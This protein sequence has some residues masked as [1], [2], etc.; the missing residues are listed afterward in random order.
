MPA[1]ALAGV[2]K[3]GE[4]PRV[5][6][7]IGEGRLGRLRDGTAVVEGWLLVVGEDEGTLTLAG[8]ALDGP[9][10]L[11]GGAISGGSW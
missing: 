2:S 6:T 9:C 7:L 10:R 11:V 8:A 3:L 5:G 4:I 1:A